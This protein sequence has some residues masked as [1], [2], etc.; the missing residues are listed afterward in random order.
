MGL[1]VCGGVL[2]DEKVVDVFECLVMF[3]VGDVVDE[4]F[5]IKF[6]LVDVVGELFEV[7][8]VGGVCGVGLLV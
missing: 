1:V 2:V 5:V 8:V 3:D 4:V 6:G 7:G